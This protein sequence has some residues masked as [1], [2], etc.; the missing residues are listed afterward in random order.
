LSPRQ[1]HHLGW[2]DDVSDRAGGG[3]RTAEIGRWDKKV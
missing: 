2:L 3:S 1:S